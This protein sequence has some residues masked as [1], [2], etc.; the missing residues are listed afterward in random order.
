[1][2]EKPKHI[3]YSFGTNEFKESLINVVYVCI[4]QIVNIGDDYFCFREA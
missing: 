1:M 4:L 3:V 2:K